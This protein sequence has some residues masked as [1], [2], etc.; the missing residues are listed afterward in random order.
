MEQKKFDLNS[1]IGML[2]LGGIMLWWMNTQKPEETPEATT[3]TEQTANATNTENNLTDNVI[4]NDSLQQI[5]LRNKFG[6]FAYGASKSQEGNTT[7]ENDVVKLTIDNKGGQIIEALVKNYKTYDSLPLYLVKDNN[8]S[9]NINFGTTDNRILNTKDLLFTPTLTKNG[10]TQVLSMKLKVSES[11]F[12]EYRYEMKKGDYRV[13]F[14]VRSQGLSNTINSSQEINLDWSLKGFRHEKSLKTEN[15][16]SYYYYKADDEVD[17]LQM[18]DDDVVSDIDWVAYKQHFFSS[19]LTSDTPFSNATLKSVDF[20]GEDKD[21]VY[22][23]TYGLKT[24]LALTNGELNYNMQ[25]FYGPTDYNLLKSYKGTSLDEIADLGWGIF[26]FLNRTIFYPVFNMLKGFIGNYGLII[27]LM[28]IVVRIIMS[29]VLYK[30]YLSSAKMKVI[31]PEMEE[32]NKKYPGKENAMKRQ[33]EI[34]AVQRKAGVSMM[35]GCIPALMQMPVFFALFKFFPTNIDFRQEGFLWA[36]DLSSYDTIFKLPFKIPFYGDHVSLFPILASV[37]IFF[38]MKMNQSQQA[39]M[40]APTQEGMPDMSKMMKWMI[41]FSPIMM[42]FFFNNY[43]SGL[44]LYY[45]I[46]NLLTI[47][48][49]FVIKN[50]VIDEAKIHAKIE[51]NKKKPVKKSKFRER[52]DAAMKQ[53]QEQQA[54][55]Q[56]AK[57]K[58]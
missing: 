35:S 30:S 4:V 51:E 11:K 56:R 43:A 17:Y 45:F 15:M 27:I 23:K 13:G 16:Y 42:L 21:S 2:L 57:N 22:T 10:D 39:N 3:Q 41:Y 48:I 32:I 49:M 20:A 50:Y 36:N 33:Q 38:Y 18:N 9:F 54:A 55:Q 52:L 29:P 44:S 25:W 24:P 26:G 5:A 46:S 14:A 58:K 12:L 8:A 19:I 7:L 31:R 6:A 37:A 28:T 1:F 40:Q 34:M 53:A 47:I